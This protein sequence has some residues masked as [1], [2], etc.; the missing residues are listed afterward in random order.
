M[1]C[2]SE[3][4]NVFGMSVIMLFFINLHFKYFIWLLGDSVPYG[5]QR[6]DHQQLMGGMAYIM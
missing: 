2:L 3:R 5:Q 6:Y 1:S 4:K